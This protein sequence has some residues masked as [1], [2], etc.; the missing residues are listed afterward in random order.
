[1]FQNK[2]TNKN[3]TPEINLYETEIS[4]LPHIEFKIA[5]TKML[6]EVR[7]TI[8]EQLKISIKKGRD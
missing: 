4:D 8:H 3:K 1:M 5:A 6:I 2:Q 7:R